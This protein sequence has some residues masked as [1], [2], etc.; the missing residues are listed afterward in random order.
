[1][2]SRLP[3]VL[4]PE[5]ERDIQSAFRWY[6]KQRSGLG[7]DFRDYVDTLMDRLGRMA[8]VCPRID[9]DVRAASVGKFP[10]VVYFRILPNAVEVLAV[11]HAS[12]DTRTLSDRLE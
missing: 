10:Y 4:R 2:K 1:M 7:A 6:N 8:D 5:V 12:R 11:L 3:V 9:G